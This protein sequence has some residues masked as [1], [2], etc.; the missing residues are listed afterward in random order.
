MKTDIE[1]TFL[2]KLIPPTKRLRDLNPR[3]RKI[4]AV[5]YWVNLAMLSAC[6]GFGIPYL[7][8]KM[9]K[10]DVEKDVKVQKLTQQI[11][12][13]DFIKDKQ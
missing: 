6:M 8:N 3:D 10:H 4:G 2:N 13:G 5:L 11:S 1:K 7:I 9:I 12:M